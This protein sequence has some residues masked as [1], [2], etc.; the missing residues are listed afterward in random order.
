MKILSKVLKITL[1]ISL[2]FGMS[3]LSPVVAATTVDLDAADDFAVLAGSGITNTNPSVVTGDAGLSPTTGAAIGLP[4]AQVTGTVYAV[5]AAGPLGSIENPALLTTAKNDLTAAYNDAAGRAMDTAVTSDLGTFNGGTLTPGVYED[6]GAPDSLSL[7]GTLTLDAQGDPNAVFIFKSGST[8]TTAADSEIT[9]INAAQACN[10]FWQVGSSAT[11]GTNSVFK[12]NILAEASITDNGG[13]VVEG[14]FL[15]DADGDGTGAVT[16]NDTTI[17][18]ATCVTPPSGGGG[19][20]PPSRLLPFINVTKIPSPLNLP[21]GPGSVTYTYTTTNIGEVAMYDVSV[22]DN[23]CAPLAFISGDTNDN[24]LLDVGEAWTHTC[25]KTVSETETNTVS[26]EGFS[27]NAVVRDTANATV[28][29]G[30]P[31]TPPLI[32][33]VKKPSVSVLPVGGGAV[34]YTYTVTNPGTEPLNNVSVID[35]KCT[36]LPG[37]VAGHPGDL[38]DNDLLESNEVWTFTC[39]TNLTQT[40]T[41]I[42]TAEGHANGLTAIDFSPATVAVDVIVPQLPDTGVAPDGHNTLWTIAGLVGLMAIPG[43][44]A[45]APRLRR[46]T[47]SK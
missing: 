35:D 24:D 20:T 16:L 15:A 3:G 17:V 8:L 36:G 30:V 44:L 33:L 2:V 5:D 26:V 12:G 27:T 4:V 22:E 28:V 42:G 7:T 1:V 19:S 10:V 9:L 13:S 38:N 21:S 31:L 46:T 11:L 41:N 43:L 32:H 34:T 45:V 29:V 37:R 18:K 14:R 6:N 39:Q 25:T 47:T 23:K 40:T